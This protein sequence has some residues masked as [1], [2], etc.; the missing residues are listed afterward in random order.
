M[1]ISLTV[2]DSFLKMSSKIRWNVI[3]ELTFLEQRVE[4]MVYEKCLLNKIEI[5]GWKFQALGDIGIQTFQSRNWTV[6]K[7]VSKKHKEPQIKLNMTL[8]LNVYI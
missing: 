7:A 2:G 5:Q 6:H 3:T 1:V 8:W 4:M